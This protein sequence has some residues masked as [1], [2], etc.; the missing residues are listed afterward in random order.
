MT[1]P[2]ITILLFAFVALCALSTQPATTKSLR[3]VKL[4][5]R[6]DIALKGFTAK[7]STVLFCLILLAGVAARLGYIAQL[8]AGID[9]QEALAI[10][11]AR[12]FASGQG[13]LFTGAWT[14][15]LNV[16]GATQAGPLFS[17]LCVPLV[18]LLGDGLLAVRLTM[19]LMHSA[20]MLAF[21][22][23]CKRMG[24][25][26]TG[27]I[28]FFYYALAPGLI[29]QSRWAYSAQLL[30]AMLVLSAYALALSEEKP[31]LYILSMLLFA[32]SMY[33]CDTAWYILI[34]FVL[35][36]TVYVCAGRHLPLKIALIGA[37]IFTFA[38]L[39]A[40]LTLVVNSFALEGFTLGFIQ[41][42]RFESYE[43]GLKSV[44]APDPVLLHG[45]DQFDM[46]I[47]NGISFFKQT[48]LQQPTSELRNTGL[49]ALPNFGLY[50][51]FMLPVALLGAVAL[52]VNACR[53]LPERKGTAPTTRIACA[54]LALLLALYGTLYSTLTSDHLAAALPLIILLCVAGFSF[55]AR[56]V[57]LSGALM[58]AMYVAAFVLFMGGYWAAESPVRTASTQY[59][60]FTDAADYVSTL[61]CEHI[62]VTS[63]FYPNENPNVCARIMTAYAFDLPADALLG[64]ESA[65]NFAGKFS[66]FYP[67]SQEITPLEGTAY[68][69][70]ESDTVGLDA[71]MFT[72]Y[73]EFGDW[74]AV[75]KDGENAQSSSVKSTP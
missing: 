9:A 19:A 17:L 33:A 35:L 21:Y 68:I 52:I 2:F 58:A 47:S 23:L 54:V 73:A 51:L 66:L 18:A 43:H 75:W 1:M 26:R 22:G 50:Q 42:P 28:G 70:R 31:W 6:A 71:D 40:I 3:R 29:M 15:Q 64:Q 14:A 34:P 32:L 69:L 16:F 74:V 63:N 11:Q 8:P 38:A 72:A 25:W 56:R 46:L 13:E 4:L 59:D 24:D 7:R 45:S 49:F 61:D 41:I 57:P 5:S 55:I 67:E 39:P 27:L 20:A 53:K 10:M 65:E 48:I 60:G 37:A 30:P 62:R 12:S 44:L 36:L